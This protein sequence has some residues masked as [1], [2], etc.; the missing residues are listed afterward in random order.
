MLLL[1]CCCL[2]WR[3][4]PWPELSCSAMEVLLAGNGFQRT[5]LLEDFCIS[6]CEVSTSKQLRKMQDA[7]VMMQGNLTSLFCIAINAA[8]TECSYQTDGLLASFDKGSP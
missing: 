5:Q 6:P 8:G 7:L 3:D 4:S 1:V 2:R